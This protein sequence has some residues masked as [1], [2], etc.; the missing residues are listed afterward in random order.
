MTLFGL[1]V[2]PVFNIFNK[3][4]GTHWNK[5]KICE[6]ESV[7]TLF[8]LPVIPVFNI[9]NKTPGTHWNKTK[10]CETE[11]RRSL[12]CLL[13][14]Y[15]TFSTKHQEPTGNK[16]K[17]FYSTSVK[18]SGE[19]ADESF[20]RFVLRINKDPSIFSVPSLLISWAGPHF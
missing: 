9:F 18:Q 2:I 3:T 17:S 5:T 1:P 6:T 10:I 20:L 8:G 12:V 13:H 7:V 19:M 14:Q 16:T 11:Q 15:L 4:P